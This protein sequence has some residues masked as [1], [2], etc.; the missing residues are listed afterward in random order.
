[1]QLLTKKAS[2]VS[3]QTSPDNRTLQERAEELKE[4][5][6][7]P[8]LER[9]RQNS[10]YWYLRPGVNEEEAKATAPIAVH[11]YDDLESKQQEMYNHYCSH[12]LLNKP[13]MYL[14][15]PKA[16]GQ[17]SFVLP[18]EGG[19]R[20]RNIQN[21]EMDSAEFNTRLERL[22]QGT[23]PVA[24]KALL[25]I[26]LAE[27]AF[28]RPIDTAK[29]LAQQLAKVARRIEEIIPAAH[30][31]EQE[32]G[33]LHELFES[34]RS[35]LLP[36][37]ELKA[38]NKKDYSFADIYAQTVA[39]ALFTAR[40]FS[41]MRW[42]ELSDEAGE[43][44]FDRES[45]WQ[46]LPE[47][48]PFLRNLFKDISKRQPKE[49]GNE[50]IG[51]IAEIFGILRLAK[52][53]AILSDFQKKGN[54]EDIVIR[55]YEDFL[56]EYNPQM[57]EER[58]V[59]ST[60]QP[61]V[62]YIVRSVDHIL[63]TDFGLAD[64]LADATKIQIQSPDGKSIVESHKVLIV[65]PA[66]G[67]G[68]FL[69]GA[70][71][72]IHSSFASKP[73][74]WSNYVAQDLLPRLLGFELLMAPYAVAHL[75]LGLQLSDLGYQF[76][77]GERLRVYLTDTLQES[78]QIPA[79]EDR[80][81]NLLFGEADAANKIKE[82]APVMVI[83]GNPPY[84]GHSV[85]NGEW[86]KNLLKGKDIVTNQPTSNYFEVDGKPITDQGGKKWLND[87]YV[88][89]IRFGQWRIEK[90]GYGV[91]AF[92]TNNN[93]LNARTFRGMR[94]S[95]IQTFDD[96]YLL[97]L[98]GNSNKQ[99]KCSD[100]S[101]DDNVFNIQ[102]GTSICLLVKK[103]DSNQN[104][105]NVYHADIYGKQEIK[106]QRLSQ[107]S[108]STTTWTKLTPES[109]DYFFI[110]RNNEFK[111]EYNQYWKIEDIFSEN[112]SP[113]PGLVTTH[114]EFAISWSQDS[115]INKVE[116][117]LKTSTELEARSIFKLCSQEQ[118]Q[119]DRAKRELGKEDWRVQVN[120]ILYRP[121][122]SRWTVFNSNVAVHRR[123]RVM[124]HM[125][126]GDNLGLSTS[127]GIEAGHKWQHIFCSDELIQHHT[128]S[129]KEVNYLFPLYLY[130]TTSAEVVMG[131]TRKPNISLAFFTKLEQ[132]LGY[133]PTPEIIFYYI[134]AIFYSSTYRARYAEFLKSEF[135]RVPLTRNTDLFCQ[136]AKYGEQLIALHL[137]KSPTPAK[138]S[139]TFIENGGGCIVNA[140]HPKYE[141]TKVIIN[142][143]QDSFIDVPEEVWN[144]HIGSYQVCQKWLKD[145]KG[146]TLSP[147]DIRHY[148]KI[149]VALGQTIELMTK[150]DEAIPN[151]PIQ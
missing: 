96:I 74:Q 49:L 70:I 67:T 86:I 47:T 27:F 100:G 144:F 118:W 135:P 94:Q 97:D 114:D 36:S 7:Y 79:A 139:S 35:E 10:D 130:P 13:V 150:I 103:L 19:L 138:T 60:P 115:A 142:K 46:Q 65:D 61:V 2:R 93:Y 105:A 120:P 30:E 149:V 16:E 40:V 55:F 1:V 22:K 123:E 140:G 54:R 88:K 43:P 129:I 107:S 146:R 116:T 69:H 29:E 26:P 24:H 101:I 90:T 23:L 102:Q 53:D 91:L 8:V 56:K 119:Y 51:A 42:K 137:M 98:H 110:P 17:V 48:N 111:S 58:G 113:A 12:D 3:K 9:D 11:F 50:L 141:G 21:F 32:D 68:T 63:K 78:F 28:Y 131:V 41:H 83:L 66:V 31:A 106:Y 73:E 39:Y 5:L 80:L 128:V 62:S 108:I 126:A 72:H 57:K 87:D 33:Y 38:K 81:S 20:Q 124:R 45:A 76:D 104:F 134:Y 59:Y 64:G 4:H 147:D 89:F 132:N 14:L 125:L 18:T 127:K 99:E 34:F 84:S 117:F 71:D 136:L 44:H 112:G 37:L 121:F 25:S 75:K 95:L 77:S 15:W 6:G 145:R 151:W 122:D 52:M 82:Q 148:Q 92:V 133:I 109:P 143:Q 85:N